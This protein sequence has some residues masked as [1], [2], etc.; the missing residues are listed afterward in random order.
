MSPRGQVHT[1]GEEGM[2]STGPGGGCGSALGSCSCR[3][4]RR[5][6]QVPGGFSLL[7]SVGAMLSC[8]MNP[9]D[10]GYNFMK[11]R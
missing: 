10:L 2:G 4:G 1:E 3:R 8:G 6:A 11:I 7:S 9:K 5:A